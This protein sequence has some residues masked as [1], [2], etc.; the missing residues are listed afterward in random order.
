MEKE[1]ID[2]QVVF[3]LIQSVQFKELKIKTY[4]IIVK[5]IGIIKIS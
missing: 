5:I 4:Q 3:H 2:N 1:I